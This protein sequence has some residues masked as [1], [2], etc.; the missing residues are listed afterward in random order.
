MTRAKNKIRSKR[1]SSK[2]VTYVNTRLLPSE[3]K[4]AYKYADD[5]NRTLPNALQ[6]IVKEALRLKGYLPK[7][8]PE[9]MIEEA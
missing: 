1:L 6:E 8:E 4:A 7:T 5:T 9:V 2:E 3:L